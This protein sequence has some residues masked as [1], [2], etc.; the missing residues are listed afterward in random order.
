MIYF[1]SARNYGYFAKTCGICDGLLWVVTVLRS[2]RDIC[3]E[4]ILHGTIKLGSRGKTVEIDESMFGHKRKYNHGR[5]GKE[6][7]PILSSRFHRKKGS[8]ESL[9]SSNG[10]S[11][12]TISQVELSIGKV[13]LISR[14]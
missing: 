4:K 9:D 14:T 5:I 13:H 3:T 10:E 2:L 8:Y 12:L 1:I 11:L 6:G 7:C